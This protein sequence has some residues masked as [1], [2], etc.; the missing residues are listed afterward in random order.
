VFYRIKDRL[1]RA[2][3]RHECRGVFEAPP[4]VL[5]SSSPAI[6][7]SQLPHKDLTM[8]L[9]ALR[10]FARYVPIKGVHLLNDG[11]VTAEDKAL[12]RDHIP[13]LVFHELAD[14][15]STACPSGGCWERL[16]GIAE[17]V[18]DHYVI[19]L[20]S[21]TLA[22]SAIDEVADCVR[23]DT[24]FTLG[25]WDRQ[26]FET[27]AERAAQAKKNVAGQDNSHIQVLAEANLDKL[28]G[29]ESLR[30]VRGCAGF[31]G[32]AARSFF[33]ERVEAL[34][35]EMYAALGSKWNTW[36]SEQFAS[37][38]I[39]ANSA[40]AVVLPHPK[41]CAC[42]RVQAETAFIHFIGSC[43]FNDGIYARLA[44]RVIGELASRA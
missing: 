34:S 41:Y 42:N 4:L 39:V 38:V 30:Y 2:H 32:F 22:I 17:L 20:D 40:H 15:R 10:S 24:A 27:M 14:F 43:R 36:G 37:N 13:G 31:A 44:R 29:Y 5:E 9:V 23:H 6:I 7:F 19:Q 12:L 35:Q 33:R 26:V 3:F 25:T 21:D 11:S 18:Q 1:R 8:F 28:S 16:L